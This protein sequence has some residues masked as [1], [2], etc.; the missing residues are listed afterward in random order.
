M[1]RKMHVRRICTDLKLNMHVVSVRD[2]D[3]ETRV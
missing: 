1:N 3:L 2:T